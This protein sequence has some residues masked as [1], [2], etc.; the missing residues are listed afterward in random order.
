MCAE[1]ARGGHLE[2]L[3][4]LHE[5]GCPWDEETCRGAAYAGHLECLKY[6]HENGCPWDEDTCEAAANGGHLECLQ[7]A[8]ENGCPMFGD[9]EY[10]EIMHFGYLD[11]DVRSYLKSIR[12]SIGCPIQSVMAK[13]DEVKTLIPEQTSRCAMGS[14]EQSEGDPISS[15][16]LRLISRDSVLSLVLERVVRLCSRLVSF[17]VVLV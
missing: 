7:Y 17:S 15:I 9:D 10:D 2:C 5:N 14:C 12:G 13:L 8:H 1:T 4:Y 3:K 16:L 11:Y 6:A